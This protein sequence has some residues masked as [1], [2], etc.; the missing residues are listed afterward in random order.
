MYPE[1]M[2]IFFALV[3]KVFVAWLAE[4]DL[5]LASFV[6]IDVLKSFRCIVAFRTLKVSSFSYPFHYIL[7]WRAIIFVL[8]IVW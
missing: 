6:P 7:F 8:T 2:M 5:M 4:N 3:H 1:F